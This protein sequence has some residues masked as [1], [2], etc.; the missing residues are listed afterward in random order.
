[1]ARIWNKDKQF[2]SYLAG[3]VDGEGTIG[4]SRRKRNRW[5]S[6][7][8]YLSISNTDIR[9]LSY[10]RERI[11]FGSVRNKK[12]TISHY[13]KKP[14]FSYFISNKNARTVIKVIVP[15][16]IVKKEQAETVLLMPKRGGTYTPESESDRRKLQETAYKQLIFLHG[17]RV[18]N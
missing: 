18:L 12:A 13:G 15:Y 3:F 5:F 17:R 16:L 11:G 8:S 4:V 10:I 14:C 1:M 2:L 9:V 6:Y 7:D